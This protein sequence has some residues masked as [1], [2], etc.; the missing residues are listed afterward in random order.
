MK[1]NGA[2]MFYPW[3]G[4]KLEGVLSE[5]LDI[6]MYYLTRTGQADA[7]VEALA[8]SVI[9]SAYNQGVKNKIALANKAIVA[10]E[11]SA[12]PSEMTEL[13]SLYPRLG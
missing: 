3:P 12:K 11:R 9:L 10:V 4:H 2:V 13:K 1:M 8:A 7:H 6:A 5:A